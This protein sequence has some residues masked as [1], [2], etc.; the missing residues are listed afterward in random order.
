MY[1]VRRVIKR[2]VR[3]RAGEMPRRRNLVIKRK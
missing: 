1:P 2:M 3:G